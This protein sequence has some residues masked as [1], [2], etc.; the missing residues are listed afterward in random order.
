MKD[1]LCLFSVVN[2][3]IR[4]FCRDLH[5]VTATL[6]YVQYLTYCSLWLKLMICIKWASERVKVSAAL[7]HWTVFSYWF[8]QYR[9]MRVLTDDKQQKLLYQTRSSQHC[10]FTSILGPGII[11]N[12]A[13]LRQVSSLLPSLCGVPDLSWLIAFS[14]ALPA[15]AS[16][17]WAPGTA[18][19]PWVLTTAFF[20]MTHSSVQVLSLYHLTASS[21]FS[22][23]SVW[24]WTEKSILYVTT[25]NTLIQNCPVCFNAVTHCKILACVEIGFFS[26]S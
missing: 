25:Q 23:S 19:I 3:Y 10:C 8:P 22:H 13:Q 18:L 26:V 12:G 7:D 5:H 15:P 9:L 17:S 21:L 1:I 14:V 11:K 2:L 24:P 6:I 20:R 16:C 4:V